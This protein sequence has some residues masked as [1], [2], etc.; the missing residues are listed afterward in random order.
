[1]DQVIK[2]TSN[3]FIHDSRFFLFVLSFCTL[4]PLCLLEGMKNVSYIS[5]IAM[6]SIGIALAYI[7]YSSIEAIN[8]PQYDRVLKLYDFSGLPYFFGIAMFMFEG[9]A[10]SL[11][12]YHQMEDGPRNFTK[13]LSF[14]LFITVALI[15]VIG[16]LSYSAYGQYT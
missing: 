13:S 14:A 10:V 2:Y 1:M 8:Y 5:L 11:E 7:L 9:N 6:A 16:S 12:I 3:D 4:A 15:L